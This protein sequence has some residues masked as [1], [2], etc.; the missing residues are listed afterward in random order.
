MGKG[1]KRPAQGAD[2][3]GGKSN[4]QICSAKVNSSNA[5]SWLNSLVHQSVV[6][7]TAIP[8]KNDRK[9]KR[10]AKKAK[11]QQQKE[12][13]QEARGIQTKRAKSDEAKRKAQ[14]SPEISKDRLQE[15][16]AALEDVRKS[17]YGNGTSNMKLYNAATAAKTPAATNKK[18]KLNR[19]WSEDSIQPR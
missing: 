1:K 12:Q 3:G 5:E 2:D 4:K 10:E 9:R 14:S 16:S 15:L 6:G 19:K 8:S 18:R 17:L 7:S 11:R 13:Q